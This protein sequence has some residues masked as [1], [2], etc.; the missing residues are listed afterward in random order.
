MQLVKYRVV[1]DDKSMTPAALLSMADE[2]VIADL[3]PALT[4]ALASWLEY[5]K[6]SSVALRGTVK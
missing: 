2:T 4:P 5:D 1:S 3:P 6:R